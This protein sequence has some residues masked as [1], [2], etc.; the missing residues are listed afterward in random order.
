MLLLLLD[1]C[2]V[3]GPILS[4]QQRKLH[5]AS[6]RQDNILL[7]TVTLRAGDWHRGGFETGA[8]GEHRVG[9]AVG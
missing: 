1:N 8:R 2:C 9:S 7:P 5:R 3:D 6:L 4:L